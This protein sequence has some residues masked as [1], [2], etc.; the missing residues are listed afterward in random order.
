MKRRLFLK[1]TTAIGAILTTGRALA[2]KITAGRCGAQCRRC[3]LQ[4]NGECAGCGTG[5]KAQ[6]LVFKCN[7]R[8]GLESCAQCKIN[9]CSKHQRINPPAS[10]LA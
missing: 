1:W 2:A 10:A 7:S 9:P 6:C 4:K 3:D 5:E 8:R